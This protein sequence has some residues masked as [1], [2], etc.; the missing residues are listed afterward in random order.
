MR[1][2]P[3]VIGFG[4]LVFVLATV[5]TAPSAHALQRTVSGLKARVRA[6]QTFVTWSN[7]P[8]P[9]WSYR[10][11]RS[12]SAIVDRKTLSDAE[13]L[14]VVEDSS[15]VDR[16]RTQVLG[17]LTT[18]SVDSAAAPLHPATGLFV[19]TIDAVALAHYAVMAESAGVI[20]DSLLLA[21]ANR[22]L[23][24]VAEWPSTP[25]PVWQRK[26]FV[27]W[28]GDDYV[29]WVSDRDAP[30]MPA[31]S[32]RAST[33]THLSVQ[34]GLP[35]RPL[36]LFGHA[37]GGTSFGGLLGSGYPGE[38]IL[39]IEDH[40]PTSDRASFTYGYVGSYDTRTYWNFQRPHGE[41]VNDYTERRT[42]FLLDWAR[43][44]LGYDPDR[45]YAWGGS[46][47]GSFAFFLSYHH[48]ERIASVLGVVPKLCTAFIPDSYGELR[49]SFD[50]IWGPLET[51][52][53]GS[54]GTPVYDWMDG[55]WL[56]SDARDS[57][58][59]PMTLFFGR[60]DTV[61]GWPE[62]VAYAAAMQ[63]NRIGG[64][65]FW[66]TRG[67]YDHAD[68]VPWRPMERARLMHEHR[69]DRSYPA[70]SQCSVD[71]DMG[72]GSPDSGDPMGTINGHLAWDT[73]IVDMPHLWSCV[74]R[75]VP[76]T[77]RGGTWAAPEQARVDVTPRRLQRFRVPA[78]GV[79]SWQ[80]TDALTGVELQSGQQ[81]VD[82][83]GLI[84]LPQ[85]MVVPGSTRLS[86]WSD[87]RDRTGNSVASRIQR[88]LELD[89]FPELVRGR[90]AMT[91]HWPAAAHA[92]VRLLDVAGRVRQVLLD[93]PV[94]EVSTLDWDPA[95]L[96][97]GLYWIEA[98]QG[99]ARLT[100]RVVVAR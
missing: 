16:R 99:E 4:A 37:R 77:H 49:A 82:P 62:K 9:D 60:A 19:H 39:C 34:R 74:L 30:D 51:T 83:D 23:G 76:V 52:P 17:W 90:T 18:F 69:L 80:V 56:A 7:I 43:G 61:V 32:N 92:R 73:T 28:T 66:D 24:P 11:Y 25:Q 3:P 85:V 45:V 26:T 44:S 81:P 55:R 100:R 96:S 64:A 86:V 38:S 21:N 13:L 8:G 46:M 42:L 31:M 94:A 48:P 5:L 89:R 72:D 50:R 10:V 93:A 70:F 2:S 84:T 27:P 88:R 75:T 6:G 14:G 1:T 15:A 53:V 36:V 87:L 33:P 91:L 59:P 97:P 20:R 29:L 12:H 41:V 35:D 71:Q 65:L 95:G 57:G 63:E 68:L 22:T 98:R 40:L 54:N 47:G 67:H 79:V 78:G 58:T